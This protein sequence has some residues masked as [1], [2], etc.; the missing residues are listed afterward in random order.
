[1]A[2]T[3]DWHVQYRR[4][5]ADHVEWFPTPEQAIDAACGLI[6]N[7]CDVHGIGFG[8]LDNSIGKDRIARIYA[9]WVMATSHSK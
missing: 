5:E 8:S 7:G 9:L 2:E 6:D 1:M 3:P 4:G